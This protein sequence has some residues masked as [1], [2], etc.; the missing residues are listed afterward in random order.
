MGHSNSNKKTFK[1]LLGL[2]GPGETTKAVSDVSAGPQQGM[3]LILRFVRGSWSAGR[4]AEMRMSCCL[5]SLNFP[6][7]LFPTATITNHMPNFPHFTDLLLGESAEAEILYISESCPNARRM[8]QYTAHTNIGAQLRI[9]GQ[10]WLLLLLPLGPEIVFFKSRAVQLRTVP[11]YSI[12]DPLQQRS[13]HMIGRNVRYT[14]LLY[15]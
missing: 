3:E 2:L 9:K 11:F 14:S 15:F 5:P 4:T 7:A 12:F 13:S 1:P 10:H 6:N 8:K